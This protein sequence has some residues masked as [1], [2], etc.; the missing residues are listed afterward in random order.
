MGFSDIQREIVPPEIDVVYHNDSGSCTLSGPTDIL[1]KYVNQLAA[2]RIPVKE[3]NCFNIPLHS[4][5]VRK[6]EKK[7]LESLK[8]VS[9]NNIKKKKKRIHFNRLNPYI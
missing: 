9:S 1:K 7:L 6:I 2:R 4:R 3:I 8:G 5:H